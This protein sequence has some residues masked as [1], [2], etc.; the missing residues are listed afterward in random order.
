MTRKRRTTKGVMTISPL[1]LA[2]RADGHDGV[3][4]PLIGPTRSYNI[5]NLVSML[6]RAHRSTTDCVERPKSLVSRTGRGVT[7]MP[8]P[9]TRLAKCHPKSSF[10]LR[11]PLLMPFF[12]ELEVALESTTDRLRSLLCPDRLSLAALKCNVLLP[13]VAVACFSLVE[14]REEVFG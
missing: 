11:C 7:F 13:C 2:T 10:A 12:I 1:G 8:G 6:I 9:I 4:P 14:T 5:D 3:A